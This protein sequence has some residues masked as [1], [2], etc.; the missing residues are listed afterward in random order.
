MRPVIRPKNDLLNSQI[1]RDHLAESCRWATS[2]AR[3]FP[4]PFRVRPD[5]RVASIEVKHLHEEK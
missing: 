5:S 3:G 1:E 4:F 2:V